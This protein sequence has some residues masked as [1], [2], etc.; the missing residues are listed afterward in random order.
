MYNNWRQAQPRVSDDSV[1]R[2]VKM[3]TRDLHA[4]ILRVGASQISLSHVVYRKHTRI[5]QS[6]FI[7]KSIL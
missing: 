2:D 5:E 1:I 6:Y 4:S 3:E 7:S